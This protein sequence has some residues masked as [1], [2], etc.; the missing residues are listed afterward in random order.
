MHD[1]V[2]LRPGF[3]LVWWLQQLSV[4]HQLGTEYRID[5]TSW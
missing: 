3:S 1:L 5:V 2:G 4:S